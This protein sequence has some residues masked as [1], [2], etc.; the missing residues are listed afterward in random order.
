MPNFYM[1]T[2]WLGLKERDAFYDIP[3]EGDLETMTEACRQWKRAYER[4][5]ASQDLRGEAVV[6]IAD[7]L[8]SAYI[9]EL[10]ERWVL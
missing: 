2:K 9:K 7:R 8:F 5:I 10:G 1:S 6:A 4:W 3:Q